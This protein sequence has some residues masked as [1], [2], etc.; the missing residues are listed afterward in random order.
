MMGKLRVYSNYSQV[1]AVK[2]FTVFLRYDSKSSELFVL[3]LN[4]TIPQAIFDLD[5]SFGNSKLPL[6]SLHLS[7]LH[8][9]ALQVLN[10]LFNFVN[11]CSPL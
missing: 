4:N 3:K 10:Y 9:N 1:I 8:D 7:F 11:P 5:F 2:R 6:H